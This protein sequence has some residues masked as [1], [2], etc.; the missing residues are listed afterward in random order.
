MAAA[1]RR[2]HPDAAAGGFR[3]TVAAGY[4]KIYSA[5]LTAAQIDKLLELEANTPS[6]GYTAQFGG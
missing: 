1:V 2:D 3:D 6:E 5:D 4:K